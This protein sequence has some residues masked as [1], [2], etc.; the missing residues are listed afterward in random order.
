MSTALPPHVKSSLSKI[1]DAPVSPAFK[2]GMVAFA[3][4]WWLSPFDDALMPVIFDEI[5]ITAYAAWIQTDWYKNRRN[6]KQAEKQFGELRNLP[7]GAN[8]KRE[9]LGVSRTGKAGSP[10]AAEVK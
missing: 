7:K 3:A 5:A 1:N 9:S 8:P 6:L 4:V 2:F 10:R